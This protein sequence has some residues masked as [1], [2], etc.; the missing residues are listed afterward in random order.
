MRLLHLLLPHLLHL[1]LVEELLLLLALVVEEVLLLHP[2]PML[3]HLLHM[4]LQGLLHLSLLGP[5]HLFSCTV[6][7]WTFDDAVFLLQASP[8]FLD[9]LLAL[10][11]RPFDYAVLLFRESFP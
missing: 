7:R 2:L 5:L 1:L 3:L 10:L 6:K 9:L 11:L 8:C 4:L